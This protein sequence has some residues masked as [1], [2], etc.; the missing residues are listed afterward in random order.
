ME[1]QS[2]N[3]LLKEIDKFSCCIISISP[4]SRVSIAK[5]L[6]LNEF[7]T[8]VYLNDFFKSIG[9]RLKFLYLNDF[10]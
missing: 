9:I 5:K 2:L 4:Q 10:L 3:E 6:S 1:K 8:H 7:D